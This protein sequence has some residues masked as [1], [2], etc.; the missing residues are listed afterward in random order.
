MHTRP[1]GRQNRNIIS[2]IL[3]FLTGNV[4]ST[5]KV[6]FRSL[7]ILTTF[8]RKLCVGSL[9]I[10]MTV[11]FQGQKP[12]KHGIFFIGY[13]KFFHQFSTRYSLN[14]NTFKTFVCRIF[15][16]WTSL[17]HVKHYNCKIKTNSQ[18]NLKNLQVK[19]PVFL[20]CL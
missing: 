4:L 12:Y 20:S 1:A 8:F 18:E 16:S 10:C 13:C 11:I 5:E 15:L 17:I 3:T 6:Y 7:S 14:N 2:I 19:S 9:Q